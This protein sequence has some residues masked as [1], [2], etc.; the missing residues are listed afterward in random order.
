MAEIELRKETFSMVKLDILDRLK[1][2]NI[3]E[4]YCAKNKITLK[5]LAKEL[6]ISRAQ[7]YN[8]FDSRM[9]D[10]H[11]L[12]DLQKKFNFCILKGSQVEKY[13]LQLEFDLFRIHQQA[14]LSNDFNSYSRQSYKSEWLQNCHFLRVN[15]Y[16]AFLYIRFISDFLWFD[17]RKYL[18]DNHKKLPFWKK[19]YLRNSESIY[20]IPEYDEVRNLLRKDKEYFIS[21]HDKE[22]KYLHE[23]RDSLKSKKSLAIQDLY[24]ED[25]DYDWYLCRK[26]S[27]FTE[28]VLISNYNRPNRSFG[29]SLTF[30]EEPSNIDSCK[31]FISIPIAGN[32]ETW[33]K[34]SGFI[35]KLLLERKLNINIR[36]NHEEYHENFMKKVFALIDKDMENI[37]TIENKLPDH[38]T[39]SDLRYINLLSSELDHYSKDENLKDLLIERSYKKDNLE[40]EADLFIRV[41]FLLHDNNWEAEQD[42]LGSTLG[43]KVYYCDLIATEKTN[44]LKNEEENKAVLID[45]KIFKNKNTLQISTLE[46]IIKTTDKGGWDK[47][48]IISNSPFPDKCI[49]FVKGTKIILLLD[50]ELDKLINLISN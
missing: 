20:R 34:Y 23:K 14:S 6:D 3:V 50:S 36:T 19:K 31:D 45:L 27:E 2:K 13:L 17:D 7:L 28:G 33:I 43:N 15:S 38:S 22:M 48:V 49:E 44:N 11:T 39:S 12:I 30:P 32:K 37:K 35:K 9:I 24:R 21:L 1:I 16:Y 46:R 18:K 10:V 4:E 5:E 25:S 29:I 47:Y 8:L 40:K 42:Y 41:H 26:I